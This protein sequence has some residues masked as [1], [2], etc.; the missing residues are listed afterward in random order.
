MKVA[1]QQC[2]RMVAIGNTY[3][4]RVG[5]IRLPS[6]SSKDTLH[7]TKKMK[8]REVILRQLG[9]TARPRVQDR[10]PANK[11][12][13]V[14]TK[15]HIHPDILTLI[16]EGPNGLQFPDDV[17]SDMAAR[18]RMDGCSFT[19][20]DMIG[21]PSCKSHPAPNYPTKKVGEEISRLLATATPTNRPRT[22]H[23]FSPSS[24]SSGR[25]PSFASPICVSSCFS[26]PSSFASPFSSPLPAPR[27]PQRI[28]DATR[29]SIAQ[30]K[31]LREAAAAPF[32]DELT[33]LQEEFANLKLEKKLGEAQAE[34]REAKADKL[35]AADLL[36]HAEDV[37][38]MAADNATLRA[39]I[40]QVSE[41]KLEGASLFN[42]TDD[43]WHAVSPKAAS[44][45]LGFHTWYDLLDMMWAMWSKVL[46]PLFDGPEDARDATMTEFEKCLITKMRFRLGFCTAT[47]GL[48]WG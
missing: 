28:C 38:R 11:Y 14:F 31:A 46:R 8:R 47:L 1:A 13:H 43:G 37:Q 6:S 15:T 45:L 27:L 36:E 39:T 35:W 5:W 18:L 26:S 22:T 19:A 21:L 42:L 20:M 34:E 7:A 4:D 17:G 33:R 32:M 10:D 3:L 40:S 44:H 12:V 48:M 2:R 30:T 9:S 16:T 23:F 41:C 25:S 29:P 24:S